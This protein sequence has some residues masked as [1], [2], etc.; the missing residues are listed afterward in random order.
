MLVTTVLNLRALPHESTIVSSLEISHSEWT[1]NDDLVEAPV[2][3]QPLPVPSVNGPQ[4]TSAPSVENIAHQGTAS[5]TRSYQDRLLNP[6]SAHDQHV[7]RLS[8]SCCWSYRVKSTCTKSTTITTTA[9]V[10]GWKDRRQVTPLL[11]YDSPT[12]Y[13]TG[14]DTAHGISLP[15]GRSQLR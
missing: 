11:K 7:Q 4:S 9:P 15:Y 12:I 3:L 13:P 1:A 8:M 2:I 6:V 5:S 14:Q 10:P